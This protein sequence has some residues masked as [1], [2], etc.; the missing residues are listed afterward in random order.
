MDLDKEY[1]IKLGFSEENA[2]RSLFLYDIARAVSAEDLV[3]KGGT[4]LLFGYGL[5]RYST[6][7]D[8]NT[9]RKTNHID[10]IIEILRKKKIHYNAMHDRREGSRIITDILFKTGQRKDKLKIDIDYSGKYM[11]SAQNIVNNNGIFM[12]NI[13]TLCYMKYEAFLDRKKARDIFDIG[14][15]IQHSPKSFDENMI[16]EINKRI[17]ELGIDTIKKIFLKDDVLKYF[18]VDEIIDKVLSSLNVL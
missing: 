4:S 6:D 15:L 16:K 13:K 2:E 18:N 1:F 10:K 5:N 17:N 12:F 11:D 8:F 7:L 9:S 14:Y 3:L